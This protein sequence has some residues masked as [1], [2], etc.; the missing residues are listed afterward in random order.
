MAVKGFFS[1]D[2]ANGESFDA[3][4][5]RYYRVTR[6]RSWRVGENLLWSSGSLSGKRAIALWRDSPGHRRNMLDAG[7]RSV[8]V[9]VVRMRSARGVFRGFDVTIAVTDFGTRS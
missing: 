4:V 7:W 3:R 2:S 6:F 5:R 9:A 8:G 1:H